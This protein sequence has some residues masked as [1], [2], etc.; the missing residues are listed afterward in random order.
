LNNFQRWR[1]CKFY[2]EPVMHM[3][4]KR[5]QKYSYLRASQRCYAQLKFK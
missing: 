5:Q 2:L 4:E 3:E 1:G